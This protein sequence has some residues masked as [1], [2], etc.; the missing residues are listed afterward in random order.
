MPSEAEEEWVPEGND[1]SEDDASSV[2]SAY[3]E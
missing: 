1:E 2:G 3:D